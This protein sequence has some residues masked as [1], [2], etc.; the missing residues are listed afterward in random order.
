MKSA[1]NHQ[2]CAGRS[3]YNENGASLVEFAMVLPLLLILVFGII[4]ASWAFAQQ[5]DVRHGAREGA[6]AAAVDFG[7][8]ATVGQAVCDRMEVVNPSE[9]ITVVLTPRTT[10]GSTGGLATIRV[11]ANLQTLTGFF[12]GLFGGT[13]SSEVEFRTEQPSSGNPSWW[14]A[15]NVPQSYACP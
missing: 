2:Q 1:E 8:L 9:G 6:R 10:D 4:E 14:G 3:R 13:V 15:I 11:D 12:P 5:N 7:N